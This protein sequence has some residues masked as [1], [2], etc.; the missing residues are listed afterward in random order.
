MPNEL[1]IGSEI[2]I[3]YLKEWKWDAEMM[4]PLQLMFFS[5]HIFILRIYLRDINFL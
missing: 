1:P 2:R 4:K 3:Y 5:V